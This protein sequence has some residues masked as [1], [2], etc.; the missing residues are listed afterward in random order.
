MEWDFT[1]HG[2]SSLV[3]DCI[4][5]V[6][7]HMN[8]AQLSVSRL[9]SH[10]FKRLAPRLESALPPVPPSLA[11][12]VGYSMA[13]D[14]SSVLMQAVECN[15]I[16]LAQWALQHTPCRRDLVN[17]EVLTSDLFAV[18]YPAVLSMFGGILKPGEKNTMKS[19][20]LSSAVERGD[21]EALLVIDPDVAIDAITAVGC[22]VMVASTPG[23][24][25]IRDHLLRLNYMF[26]SDSFI[27]PV[28]RNDR[29]AMEWLVTVAGA[30][31]KGWS[32]D[33]S[34]DHGAAVD[35]STYMRKTAINA[36][37]VV[38]ATLDTL[39]WLQCNAGFNIGQNVALMAARKG[40]RDILHYMTVEMD[41]F[42]RRNALLAAAVSEPDNLD[43]VRQIFDDIPN[44]NVLTADVD[45]LVIY[46]TAV[47]GGSTPN[48]TVLV[49][50]GGGVPAIRLLR[51]RGIPWTLQY[52]IHLIDVVFRR[53][54]FHENITSIVA[55]LLEEG[56]LP[57]GDHLCSAIQAGNIELADLLIKYGAGLRE[58][59][60]HLRMGRN[61]FGG[62]V[63]G[64]H[65]ERLI[66]WLDVHPEIGVVTKI[67]FDIS[68]PRWRLM[69]QAF[70]RGI[71]VGIEV[72]HGYGKDNT[73]WVKAVCKFFTDNPDIPEDRF[74]IGRLEP[75][76]HPRWLRCY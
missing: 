17:H 39:K 37:I 42:C 23:H 4:G 27:H 2:L 60:F 69:A 32:L 46:S 59:F 41:V 65:P 51:E 14:A 1:V 64:D 3:D 21:Y 54:C 7:G 44:V 30:S 11:A 74:I 8:S 29:E 15:S 10:R 76:R 25:K 52:R 22:L 63:L 34:A 49:G 20:L 40:R 68:Q 67:D 43:I 5:E 53:Q 13:R 47:Y 62:P 24:L 19:I 36:N 58:M 33:D 9:I 18:L 12:D 45:P 28:K 50:G 57:T 16:D 6:F 35:H 61:S 56:V 31:L 55:Y 70:E 71:E 38:H 75:R 26:L 73:D 72:V 66:A 48:G